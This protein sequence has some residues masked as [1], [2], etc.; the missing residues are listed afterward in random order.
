[1]D[2]AGQEHD[3]Q[4]GVAERPGDGGEGGDAGRVAVV[5]ADQRHQ[6]ELGVGAVG[7]ADQGQAVAGG[8]GDEVERPAAAEPPDGHGRVGAEL[9]GPEASLV[10]D[11]AVVEDEHVERG[12]SGVAA[13]DAEHTGQI[14]HRGT[15]DTKKNRPKSYSV[16]AVARG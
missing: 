3:G 2:D 9:V 11:G 8:A 1:M 4:P 16:S 7:G 13:G 5:R 12:G 6:R 10:G 15:T 14:N